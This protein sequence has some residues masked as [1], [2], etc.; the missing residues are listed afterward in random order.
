[1]IKVISVNL[2]TS[3]RVVFSLLF[4]YYIMNYSG[5]IIPIV[6]LFIM[7]CATDFFDG[8]LA[9][10][11]DA[12]TKFGAIFDVMADL[13]FIT[14]AYSV[15]IIKN[16][17]PVWVLALVLLKFSEFCVTS[18]ISKKTGKCQS[19]VFLFDMLGRAVVLLFYA[20]PVV[21]IL[22]K[23]Y[24]YPESLY[25]VVNIIGYILATMACISSFYRIKMCLEPI[26]FQ[27]IYDIVETEIKA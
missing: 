9:R 26:R 4:A 2:L 22:L 24:L 6:I 20:L 15:L 1:M 23:N 18:F 17:L 21:V 11:L 16:M 3:L 10:K 19:S 14:T 8:R 12:G 7:I 5:D 13:F 27:K 25:L